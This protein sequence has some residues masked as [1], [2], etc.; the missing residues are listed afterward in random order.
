MK[1]NF[2]KSAIVAGFF[3]LT[4][5]SCS[6][7]LAKD[8][9]LKDKQI[10]VSFD[11]ES[12][13]LT[14]LE[15]RTTH[16]VIEQNPQ[17]G[18]S[19]RLN[20]PVEGQ[21]DNFVLGRNQHAAEVKKISSHQ[22]QL[23][24]EN[25]AS[26]HGGVL[27][28]TLTALV[29]LTN[30]TL[31]FAAAVEN[32][33]PYMVSTVDFPYLG[34]L[35][36]PAKDQP[37]WSHYTFYGDLKTLP[38]TNSASIASKQSLFC[39]IQS[40]NQGVY[41]EMH[42]PTQ[43][44]LLH[45]DFE[46]RGG[47]GK[48][49]QFRTTHFAY[50]HPH[51]SMNLAPIVMRC[52]Q[53]DWHAGLDCYREWRQTWFV[54]PHLPAWAR[55]VHSWTMLRMNTTEDDY[56]IPY[57][58]FVSYGEE[59]ASNGV[60]AVQ[61]VGWNIGGQD[62]GD[63]SQDVD[64]NLG[65]WQEFHDAIAKVQAKGVKVILFAKLNWADLTT[66]WYT[67]ELYKYECTDPNGKRYEQ[68]GYAYV[69]PTQLAGMALHHRAIMD[70]Q[71]PQYR[72]VAAKEFDKVLALGSEGWLWDEVC[73]HAS[74]DYSWAP[75]HGYTPP[76]YVYG[77]DMPLSA[78]LRAAADKVSPD[79]I[80]AGEG[81]QDWLMQYYPV[82]E[83]G[84][85][86]KPI[87]QYLDTT[88]SLMLAGV[89][90]F[91]DREGLNMIL[92]ARCVI[93]YEPYFYKGRL[94]DFPMTLAYGKKIDD[95]RRRYKPYLWDGQFRDTLGA[96]VTANGAFRYSVFITNT[97]KRAVVIV[98]PDFKKTITAKLDLPHSGNLVV[99]TPEDPDAKPTSGTVEIPARSAAVVMEP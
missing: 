16:W 97:G 22:I 58:N 21:S 14:R 30:G 64:P 44:Y 19:F 91:D 1:I 13:A 99:A 92:L 52:Y 70:F 12:G 26:E 20:A 96:T 50:V 33:S 61:L 41:V 17:L 43:P 67:N 78:R 79:F 2:N 63:P 76:G 38:I 35:T 27:P 75:N 84:V 18:I 71:D 4:M 46:Q 72:D 59:Y 10:V 25:L 69:S 40:T 82:S 42:D 83:T 11:S 5:A 77:G 89:S 87:C 48:P 32:N 57:T 51:S 98:N 60:R 55:E 81:P 7:A 8:V 66:S 93:Q 36:Q 34:D 6:P 15:N 95:L 31:T 73:H 3:V 53:G 24:W 68:G 56:T 49:E 85:T 9:T 62:G 90:G 65:T 86:S 23:K 45:F 39:F 29:S 37:L 54:E 94:S 74:A 28:I 88:N 47:Q 80:F